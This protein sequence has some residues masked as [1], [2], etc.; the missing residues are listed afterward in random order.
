MSTVK[1]L[2]GQL[3]LCHCQECPCKLQ[4]L[5]KFAALSLLARL[6]CLKFLPAVL[7]RLGRNKI[8]LGIDVFH[9]RLSSAGHCVV[10]GHGLALV[11]F[12]D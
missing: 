6:C 12:M 11:N 3:G 10:W 7:R 5:P 4:A 9:G 2:L 1:L 8:G